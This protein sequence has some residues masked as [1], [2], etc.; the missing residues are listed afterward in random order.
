MTEFCV[1]PRTNN[2]HQI[3]SSSV[4]NGNEKRSSGLTLYSAKHPLP[5]DN[6]APVV[7]APTELS[8]VDFNSLVTIADHFT[9]ALELDQHRLCVELAPVRVGRGPEVML[10]LDNVGWYVAEDVNRED[11]NVHNGEV[12]L[13]TT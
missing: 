11:H 10:L 12:I 2:G 9:T 1:R 3:T 6:V 13:P 4:W 8:L 7:L 5:F